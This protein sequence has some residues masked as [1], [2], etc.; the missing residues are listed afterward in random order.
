MRT[1]KFTLRGDTGDTR[2]VEERALTAEDALVQLRVNVLEHPENL[3][4]RYVAAERR[5]ERVCIFTVERMESV[6]SETSKCSFKYG[7]LRCDRELGHPGGHAVKAEVL[8][9]VNS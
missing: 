6:E 5:D 3:R 2:Q 7:G 8:F 4:Y 9:G 1:Y